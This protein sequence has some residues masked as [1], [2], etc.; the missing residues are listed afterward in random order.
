MASRKSNRS[1]AKL[2]RKSAPT[3]LDFEKALMFFHAY[4]YGPLQGKLRLYKARNVRSA[5]QVMSS[6]WEVFASILVKDVGSKLAKGVDLAGHEVKSAQ[7]AGS[8]EYQYHK[9]GGKQKLKDDMKVDHLFFSHRDNLRFVE[10]RYIPGLQLSALF[11]KW[12]KSFPEPYGQRY[13]CQIPYGFVSE[14]GT[15]LM[16][17]ENGEVTYPELRDAPPKETNASK[18]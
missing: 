12:L 15:L 18:S 14:K 16:R 8:F 1:S 17:L 4:M 5:G 2:L 13:R 9:I 10:L 3:D 6:D 11:K 7:G